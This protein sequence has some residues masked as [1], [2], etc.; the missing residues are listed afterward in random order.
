MNTIVDKTTGRTS[1]M[2]SRVRKVLKHHH[3]TMHGDSVVEADLIEAVLAAQ[4]V[5]IWVGAVPE[6]YQLVA[7]LENFG[8]INEIPE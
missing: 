4:K 7:C 5:P 2:H 8:S 3:L 6:G 1:D